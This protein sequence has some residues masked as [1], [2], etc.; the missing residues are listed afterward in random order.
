MKTIYKYQLEIE[1]SQV[2]QMPLD[3]EILKVDTQKAHPCLWAMVE[4][5]HVLEDRIIQIRGTGHP[6]IGLTKEDYLGT[7]IMLGGDL[8]FHVFEGV[9]K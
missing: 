6:A 8:V 7:F 5:D 2:V 1:D 4:T 9:K 3:A